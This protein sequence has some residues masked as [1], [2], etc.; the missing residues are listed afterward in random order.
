MKKGKHVLSAKG[1][2]FI[3]AQGSALGIRACQSTSAESAIHSGAL[4]RAFSARLE[5]NQCP[6]AM[7]QGCFDT[8]P[9]AL[10]TYGMR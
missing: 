4:S 3:L 8:A 9:L 5:C 7:P 2:A 1:A 6:G 10:N